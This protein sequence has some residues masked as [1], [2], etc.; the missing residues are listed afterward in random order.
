[1]TIPNYSRTIVALV[2]LLGLFGCSVDSK[3]VG[4]WQTS[5][6]GRIAKLEV[7]SDGVAIFDW[8][9]AK[10]SAVWQINDEGQLE[11]YAGSPIN[12]EDEPL[13]VAEIIN[14]KLVTTGKLTSDEIESLAWESLSDPGSSS[15]RQFIK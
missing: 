5:H 7:R 15:F 2:F 11:L 3:F 1:M 14:Y 12:E 4:F 8:R 9:Q 6:D 10:S 13:I